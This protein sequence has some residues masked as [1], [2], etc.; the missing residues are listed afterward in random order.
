MKKVSICLLTSLLISFMV[1]STNAFAEEVKTEASDTIGVTY[2][3]HIENE[4][5]LQGWMADGILSGSQG[6][7][8]RLEGIEIELTGNIPAGMGIQYQ[9]HI[10]NKGWSQGWIS[11][12]ETA[13]SVGEGLRLEAIEIKLTGE[14]ASDYTVRYRTHIQNDGWAQGWVAD[15]ALSGSEGKGLRL[16]AIEIVIEKTPLKIAYDNYLAALAKVKQADYTIVSWEAYQKVVDANIITKDDVLIEVTAATQIIT[17][18]QANLVKKADLT[19]YN[20]V[21]GNVVEA[22]CTADSWKIYQA[23]VAANVVTGEDT[24]AKVDTATIAILKAQKSLVNFADLTEYEAVLAAVTQDQ[25]KSG[26]AAYKAVVDAN[27]VTKTNTQE[28]VDAATTAILTAQKK[29]VL[30]SDLTAFNKAIELFVKYGADAANAPYTAATWNAYASRCESYGTLTAGQWV[31]DGIT[32]DTAQTTIDAATADLNVYIASLIKTVDLT[33]FNKAKN[34]KISDGPYTTT[35]FTA[36]TSNAQVQ[37]IANIPADT[38]KSYSQ[39]VVDGYTN[40]L[41]AL[42]QGILVMGSNLTNYNAALAAA[43]ESNYTS[44]SWAIYQGIVTTNV[45]TADSSQT[46]VDAAT[47][48]IVEAQKN[49]IYTSAYVVANAKIN[50]TSFGIRTVGDNVLTIAKDLMATAGIYKT[51]YTVTFVRVDTGTAVINPTTG[52]ITDRGTG[53]ATVTFNIAPIDGAVAATT[54]NVEILINP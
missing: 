9:T 29:L 3:T 31:Y 41:I 8:L 46:A 11:S 50:S 5:W 14:N 15:G 52:A 39:S 49:L 25:V 6:K 2:R 34:I 22:D 16:E 27:V 40:T 43:T 18:A 28:K 23:V 42:Q 47:A 7:G 12:G 32:K 35:S 10:E 20:D 24:Q 1:L 38:L 48:K 51:D 36:Y 21:L 37:A 26:W 19:V 45:V 54:S 13:G 44:A 53:V 17:D 33:A 4:G 30:Y